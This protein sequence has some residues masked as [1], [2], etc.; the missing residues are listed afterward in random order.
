MPSQ[1]PAA[2]SP[3]QVRPPALKELPT[4]TAANYFRYSWSGGIEVQLVVGYVDFTPDLDWGQGDQPLQYVTPMV[5]DRVFM[6]VR[7]FAILYAQTLQCAKAL[8]EAGVPVEQLAN[9][10]LPPG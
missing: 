7:G 6:S 2:G 1:S 8:Q 10:I 9:E 5:S 3:I 4:P